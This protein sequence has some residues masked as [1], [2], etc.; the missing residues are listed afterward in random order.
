MAE[1]SS[2]LIRHRW[3]Y[4]LFLG[5]LF[6]VVLVTSSLQEPTSSYPRFR[7]Q[8]T[9]GATCFREL[10]HH[11]HLPYLHHHNKEKIFGIV[12]GILQDK[13]KKH[14]HV[15]RTSSSSGSA[16]SSAEKENH[17]Q[18]ITSVEDGGVC[19]EEKW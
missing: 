12:E 7:Y 3:G 18:G 4:H 5:S 10:R 2:I 14:V 15:K 9:R 1:S 6:L 13:R 16:E 17:Q 8:A 19:K 11:R